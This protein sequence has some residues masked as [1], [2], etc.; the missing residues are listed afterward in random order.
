MTSIPLQSCNKPGRFAFTLIE[1]L[2]V[3]AIIAILAAILFPVFAQARAKARATACLSNEKQIALA[4]LAYT[5]D[6]D[7]TMVK[8]WYGPNGFGESNNTTIYKWMDAIEPFVKNTQLFSCPDNPKGLAE[9]GNESARG[10]FIPHK[11]L[12]TPNTDSRGSND[13]RY[14]G[15]YALNCA[16]WGE[17]LNKKGPGE[18]GAAMSRIES[19]ADTIW[20]TDGNGC[21]QFAWPNVNEDPVQIRSEGGS[22]FLCG[23]FFNVNNKNE[24]AIVDRHQ[25]RLNV[26]YCDGHAKNISLEFL[27]SPE[28]RTKLPDGTPDLD[29]G[30]IRQLTP[31][32]D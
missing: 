13:N 11:Q 4:L 12:G 28:Q 7:E 20:V 9:E 6:Y 30:F 14:Y 25:G 18:A 3:I 10:R 1:L 15:S 29:R 8:G 26:V 22:K 2:V 19:P 21:Y 23:A 31:A 24:G 27:M 17:P 5:Q 16:Y 32:D